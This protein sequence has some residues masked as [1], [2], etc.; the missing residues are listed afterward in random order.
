MVMKDYFAVQNCRY[1][2]NRLGKMAAVKHCFPISKVGENPPVKATPFRFRNL[3]R[4]GVLTCFNEFLILMGSFPSILPQNELCFK[5]KLRRVRLFSGCW[6]GGAWAHGV[7]HVKG[8][9]GWECQRGRLFIFSAISLGRGLRS[10]LNKVANMI[11]QRWKLHKRDF[12]SEVFSLSSP[13]LP[14]TIRMGDIP[15]AHLTK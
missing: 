8:V 12:P 14:C 7:V 9:R 4:R 2:F 5:K 15:G 3:K 11:F 10:Y 6:N 13:C 1:I